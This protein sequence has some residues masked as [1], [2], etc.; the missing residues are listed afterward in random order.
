MTGMTARRWSDAELRI[1][2]DVAAE[3]DVDR[4][5]TR[6]VEAFGGPRGQ[7]TSRLLAAAQAADTLRAAG[8]LD[9]GDGTTFERDTGAAPIPPGS[10]L[11]EA[12]GTTPARRERLAS[13]LRRMQAHVG[14]C[15]RVGRL[16]IHPRFANLDPTILECAYETSATWP[17][18]LL[19]GGR[20][21]LDGDPWELRV[22][23][24]C[25]LQ[26]TLL[27]EAGRP[28][29]VGTVVEVA[30]PA[31]HEAWWH[32]LVHASG[33]YDEDNACRLGASVA[34]AAAQG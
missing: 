32:E 4:G 33:V 7:T 28:M 25:A 11:V 10:R 20:L 5:Q 21:T 23:G 15:W 3:P 14:D 12:L 22:R 31:D 1:I 24:R 2:A 19:P 8:Q 17:L 16:Y 6:L 34:R 27:G 13:G 29:G 9:L 30:D 18:A 26:V